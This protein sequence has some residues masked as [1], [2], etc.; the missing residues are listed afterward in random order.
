MAKNGVEAKAYIDKQLAK[1]G[2]VILPPME[3]K[4]SLQL[5]SYLKL[6]PQT[7]I[8]DPW[9]NR[10]TGGVREDYVEYQLEII[11]LI[12]DN[13]KHFFFWGFPEIAAQFINKIEKPLERHPRITE[14]L[15]L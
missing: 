9:Y 11:D 8:L 2:V 12:K 1:Q 13:T 4:E 5:M 6:C 10:G 14:G 3:A 7:T 15:F